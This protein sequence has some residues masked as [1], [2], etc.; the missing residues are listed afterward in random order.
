MYFLCSSDTQHIIIFNFPKVATAAAL[1]HN[2]ITT[3]DEAVKD[4]LPVDYPF[5]LKEDDS[6]ESITEMFRLA[7]KDYEG[8]QILWEKGLS[9]M[10]EV[11]Q[12]L[13][14]HNIASEYENFLNG[15]FDE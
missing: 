12:K 8:D 10:K 1:G 6:L 2:I 4:C 9:M 15:L 13:S 3:W 14:L 7:I 5:A 11:K